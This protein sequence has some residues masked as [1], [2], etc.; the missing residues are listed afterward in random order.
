MAIESI[1]G[2]FLP[3]TSAQ[4]DGLEPRVII[5]GQMPWRSNPT[6]GENSGGNF[7]GSDTLVEQLEAYLE[8]HGISRDGIVQ[9]READLIEHIFFH[10]RRTDAAI[11]NSDTLPLPTVVF[12][13]PEMRYNVSGSRTSWP[14]KIVAIE[15]LCNDHGVPMLIV[16]ENL[17]LE[18]LKSAVGELLEALPEQI[19]IPAIDIIGKQQG[20]GL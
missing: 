10:G 17:S 4:L 5:Y 14:T 11:S 16:D 13:F 6:T 20:I 2:E 9:S 3:S 1:D 8:L 12:V 7:S 18:G 19:S 15:K